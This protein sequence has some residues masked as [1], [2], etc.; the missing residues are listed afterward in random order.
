MIYRAIVFDFNGVLL[1]DADLQVKSWQALA[2]E[3]RGYETTEEELATHMHGRP[4]CRRAELPG[5]SQSCRPRAARS[6][7]TQGVALSAVCCWRTQAN[8]SSRRVRMSLL[9][10]WC[11]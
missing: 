3:L 7:S 2:R 11:W 1:W 9:R 4:K 10:R 5:G 6:D 8:L